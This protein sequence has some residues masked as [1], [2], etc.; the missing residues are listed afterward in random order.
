M[1]FLLAFHIPLTRSEGGGETEEEE[2]VEEEEEGGEAE[3]EVLFMLTLTPLLQ[4]E[5]ETSSKISSSAVRVITDP[6]GR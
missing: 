1:S 4:Y 2:E 6:D 3:G 5:R